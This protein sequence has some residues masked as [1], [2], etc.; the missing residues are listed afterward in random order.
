MSFFNKTIYNILCIT[1]NKKFLKFIN[2]IGNIDDYNLIIPNLYLGNINYA[3]N[4]DF[5]NENNIGAI[6]NCTENEPFNEYFENKYK[7]RLS[8]NDSKT[9]ENINNFKSEIINCINFIDECLNNNIPVYVHCYWGLMRSATVVASY[10]IKKY[11][12]PYKDAI[13][14]IKEQRPYSLL[15]FYNFNEVLKYVEETYNNDNI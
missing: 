9:D 10:L 1:K 2:D 14:I 11:N 15:S 3:N 12:I 4:L 6:I 5:L 13:N 7:F 8:I